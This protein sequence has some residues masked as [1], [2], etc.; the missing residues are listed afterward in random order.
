MSRIRSIGNLV[1]MF[2]L[3]D[4]SAGGAHAQSGNEASPASAAPIEARS[5]RD[6][7]NFLLGGYLWTT[8]LHGDLTLDSQTIQIDAS[9]IDVVKATDSLFS[10]GLLFVA[11]KDRWGFLVDPLYMKVGADGQGRLGVTDVNVAL[12]I[13]IVETTGFYTFL[14]KVRAGAGQTTISM[15][16]ILGLRTWWIRANASSERDLFARE[17]SQAWVDPLAGLIFRFNLV[18][19]HVPILVRGDFGGWGV[20]SSIAWAA[21]G[22]VG[23]RWILPRLD[24][25]I[26]LAYRALGPK[27]E[28]DGFGWN[29]VMHGP[30]LAL[31]FEF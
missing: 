11:R 29:V 15:D 24:I 26:D 4:L 1:L 13:F 6:G 30:E 12:R 25:G 20:G 14:R 31:A 22:S 27:Y 16:A 3:A 28:K 17:G 7:W 5:Q 9:F 10:L 19:G 23:Y 21:T 2:A 18:R 8:A